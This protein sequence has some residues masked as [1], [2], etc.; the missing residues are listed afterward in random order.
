VVAVGSTGTDVGVA[1]SPPD[2]GVLVGK[3]PDVAVAVGVSEGVGVSVAGAGVLVG[4]SLLMRIETALDVADAPPPDAL[5]I[6][7]INVLS[8][9]LRGDFTRA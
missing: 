9:A 1:V 3:P 8:S 6:F 7:D 5:A 4:N 2:V